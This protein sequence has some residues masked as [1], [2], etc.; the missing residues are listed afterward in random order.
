[1]TVH[2]SSSNPSSILVHLTARVNHLFAIAQQSPGDEHDQLTV[3][4]ASA[5]LLLHLKAM[6][7]ALK[8][9]NSASVQAHASAF[10]G[11]LESVFESVPN[12]SADMQVIMQDIQLL[13][14]R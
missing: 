11:Q 7:K 14:G 6:Q 8:S 9:N 5:A 4:E 2:A 1:M 3:R 12:A 13:M 10:L